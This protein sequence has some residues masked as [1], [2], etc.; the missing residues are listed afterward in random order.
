MAQWGMSDASSNS[1]LW[2]PTSV[3]LTPNT[4]NRD[5]L[6]D[7]TTADAF[8]TNLTV[9]QFGADVTEQQVARNAGQPKAAHAGWVLRTVGSGGRA[10]RVQYETLV[11]SGSLTSDASDDATLPDATI[12]ITVQPAAT[13]SAVAAAAIASLS[14]VTATIFP[15]TASIT[16]T[17]QQSVDGGATYS[18][19]NP[20]GGVFTG[21]N[22]ATLGVNAG[23]TDTSSTW[24][25]AKFRCVL[26]AS[27]A[28]TVTSTATTLTVTP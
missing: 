12:T 27:G 6:F 14:T 5:A 4:T 7:N 25:G 23:M 24:N 8:I 2:A 1:V 10:N 11:A 3:K 15:T 19:I 18:N 13:K 20:N 17:W 26:T 21:A 22:T 9:G 28:A 16:Y